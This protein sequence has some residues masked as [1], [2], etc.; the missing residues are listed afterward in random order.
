MVLVMRTFE[1][2]PWQPPTAPQLTG[3]LA[4]NDKL[5]SA[6]LWP[7]PAVGPEDVVIDA[8]GSVI[9][10]LEDGT[11][12]R[13]A[14]TSSVEVIANVGGRPL[15]VEWLDDDT[16]VVCNT[17]K[18]IQRV[19]MSGEVTSLASSFE[20]VDFLFT[21]NAAVASDGT[22]Y[23]SDSS[24]RW[25]IETFIADLLEC[26][27]SGRVFSHG[28]DGTLVKLVDG[29]QFANGVALDPAEESIFVAET[30]RYRV[31]RF[32]VKG[33]RAGQSEVFLDNMAGFPDNLTFSEGILWVAMTS[34]RQSMVDSMLPRPWL[35]KII[36]RLPDAVKPKALQ[37]GM[38]LGYDL[39][40][41]LVHNLQDSTGRVGTTTT[42]RYHDGR[43]F[44]AS[45]E[46]PQV[47][48]YELG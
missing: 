12:V 2:R 41:N 40:G 35:K 19:T 8:S 36:H 33:E 5:A 3:L 21:N 6:E 28:P 4:I 9:T 38:I 1:P 25:P 29:L 24:T 22:I 18:G 42:A 43:L 39:D 10:G 20:G 47:A 45:L 44:I 14:G 11:I 13:I 34:P 23:F 26:R 27:P 48:V 17:T 15:G 32:W 31:H 16:I 7:T 37:H 46:S 30:G